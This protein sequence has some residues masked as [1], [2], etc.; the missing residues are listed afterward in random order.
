LINPDIP[1]SIVIDQE[2]C[3]FE[4]QDSI[5]A[6]PFELDQHQIFE[7]HIDILASY[8]FPEIKLEHEYVLEPQIDNSILLL[9]LLLTPVSLQS[10]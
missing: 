5:S 8:Q 7:N 3:C 6:H 2:S 4:N 9:N 1:N 10:S